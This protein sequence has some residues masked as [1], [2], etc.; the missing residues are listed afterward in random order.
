MQP[1]DMATSTRSG[2]GVIPIPSPRPEIDPQVLLI[3]ALATDVTDRR[4]THD[5]AVAE[6]RRHLSQSAPRAAAEA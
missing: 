5:Q 3:R 1:G 2:E 6:L 4:L